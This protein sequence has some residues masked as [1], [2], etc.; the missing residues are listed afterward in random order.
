LPPPATVRTVLTLDSARA[1]T[2]GSPAAL[3]DAIRRGAD[4][5]IGTAFRHNEHI[6]PASPSAE[7][8]EEVAEFRETLLIEDRWAAGIMTLRVPVDLPQGFGPRPS[9]SFFLYNQDGTQAIARPYLDGLPVQ[10]EQGEPGTGPGGDW[11]DMPRYHQF[12]SIDAGTNAPAHNFVYDFDYYR[13]VVNDRWT[14]VL[15]HD[16]QG[17][18]LSGTVA[19]LRQ[20]FLAGCAIK[21][22]LR[23]L[24]ADLVPPGLPVPPHEVFVH[25]GS[26]YYYTESNLFITGT[27]PAVRLTPAVPLRYG[28]RGWDFGW[29]VAR[30]DGHLERWLVDPQ[31]LAFGRSATRCA[32]RWFIAGG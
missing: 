32:M 2:G 25:A 22:A 4:L 21:V 20:A 16:A 12:D 29:F 5:R 1:V 24:C 31:T 18:V 7:P 15:S 8:I 26:C 19:A 17:H 10:G 9:M 27:H 14:E 28:S 30:S 6:D 3:A 13:F 11:P 23:D